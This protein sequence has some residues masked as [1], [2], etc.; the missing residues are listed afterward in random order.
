M[1]YHQLKKHIRWYRKHKT[2]EI[3][4]VAISILAKS[5]K[6]LS[7]EQYEECFVALYGDVHKTQ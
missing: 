2:E 1:V 4:K 3:R 6:I 5:A 7:R